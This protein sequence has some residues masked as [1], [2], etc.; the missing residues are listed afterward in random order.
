MSTRTYAE[1]RKSKLGPVRSMQYYLSS[2]HP[3]TR[4]DWAVSADAFYSQS[5]IKYK[6]KQTTRT[7]SNQEISY[8]HKKDSRNDCRGFAD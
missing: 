1:Q 8:E 3:I 6:Y 4:D 7:N 2:A 5:R